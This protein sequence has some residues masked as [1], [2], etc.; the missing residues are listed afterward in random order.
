LEAPSQ[1]LR[2]SLAMLASP[3]STVSLHVHMKSKDR[4]MR[5]LRAI[6][7]SITNRSALFTA[8]IV[9]AVVG[10][11]LIA[12]NQGIPLILGDSM[13]PGRWISTFITP[14]VPFLV[15]CHGQGIKNVS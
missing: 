10:S 14:L 5:H 1:E 3:N 11:C 12:I 6:G 15:S 4:I 7:W 8:I 13:T 9:A 2:V